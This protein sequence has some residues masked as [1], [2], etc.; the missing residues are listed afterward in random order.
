[1]VVIVPHVNRS[2]IKRSLIDVIDV[3][4][5]S[6]HPAGPP[7]RSALQVLRGWQ[8]PIAELLRMKSCQRVKPL[9]SGI[10]YR[11]YE[12]RSRKCLVDCL[13]GVVQTEGNVLES[14]G[15]AAVA[16]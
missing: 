16:N 13:V 9:I 4:V 6:P 10:P 1:M 5:R 15:A 12:F 8:A 11:Q 7:I 2:L 3:S 14:I